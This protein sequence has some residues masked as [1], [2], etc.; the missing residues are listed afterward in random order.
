MGKNSLLKPTSKKKKGTS[1]K[2][3]SAVAAKTKKTKAA[4]KKAAPKPKTT[5]KAK[6]A[7]KPK[8]AA[9]T[10]AATKPKV[11]AKTKPAPKA[12]KTTAVRAQKAVAPKKK[13]TL[14]ELVQK[15]FDPW[16]PEKRFSVSPDKEYLK[17]FVAPPFFERTTPKEEQRIKE[18]LFRKFDVETIRAAGKEAAAQKAAA[19]KAAAEKVVAGKAAAEKMTEPEASITYGPPADLDTTIDDP[20][21]KAMKYAAA[22]LILL[23]ALIIGASYMNSNNYYIEPVNGAVEIRQGKFSPMGEELLI[24]L[25]G[26]Q[27]PETI[28]SVYSKQEVYPL[29]F[30]YYVE[31]ADTL[32]EVSGLPDFEGIRYYLNKALPYAT[33]NETKDIAIGRL[34]NIDLMILLYKS[35]VAAD[36]GTVSGLEDAKRYL[37][38]A[39][40]LNVD[41]IKSD[42][43][44]QRIESIDNELAKMKS[45]AVEAAAAKEAESA[46]APPEE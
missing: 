17:N 35:D 21:E 3:D 4:T 43:I 11:T 10:K 8:V 40:K 44:K 14:K 15:K 5:P 29:I 25:P 32:L 1:T 33:S 20:M 37:S 6:A 16:K 28:K 38:E 18:L 7:P 34:N 12:K 13:M 24:I 2:E 36:K 42:L 45:K 31:K 39:S 46:P 19:E 26:V 9:K 23:V 22:V 27:P 30:N 41:A